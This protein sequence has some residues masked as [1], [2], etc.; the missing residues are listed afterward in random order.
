MPGNR[1]VGTG[2]G[3]RVSMAHLDVDGRDLRMMREAEAKS[4]RF[5]LSLSP[6]GP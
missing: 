3:S 4:F 2:M 1:G 5:K 6:L